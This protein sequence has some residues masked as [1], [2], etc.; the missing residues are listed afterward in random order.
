MDVREGRPAYVDGAATRQV[1]GC[2][3]FPLLLLVPVLILV[4]LV[5]VLLP[6]LLRR[7]R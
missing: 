2:G 3:F 5:V 7:P 6:L 1:N 4:L